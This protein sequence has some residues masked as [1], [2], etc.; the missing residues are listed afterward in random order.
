[1][2]SY[3]PP[4][5]F[6]Y[7]VA[8]FRK[9]P[10]AVTVLAIIGIVWGALGALS[11]ICSLVPYVVQ[12]SQPNPVLDAVRAR[13]LLHAW[14]ILS[15]LL[16]WVIAIILLAGS[17]AALS[18]RPWGRLVMVGYAVVNLVISLIGTFMLIGVML[19]L[20]QPMLESGD[21]V[22]KGGAV[23]GILGAVAGIG[24]GLLFSVFI[25]VFMRR[26][27]VLA[28]FEEGPGPYP[29]PQMPGQ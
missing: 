2:S 28:A 12:S 24:L 23:G 6:P 10:T 22:V 14:T 26:P 8:P 7:A 4:N 29:G 13:P 3:P 25:L 18:L 17:I 11:G 27:E 9:R 16:S 19:P 15:T 5:V 1:M 20:M 21:P